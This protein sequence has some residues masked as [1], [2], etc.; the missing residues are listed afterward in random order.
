MLPGDVRFIVDVPHQPYDERRAVARIYRLG[1]D[2]EQGQAIR[3]FQLSGLA[4]SMVNILIA[5]ESART[6]D[7]AS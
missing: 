5:Y 4:E 7:S 3:T 1:A 2:G 6:N